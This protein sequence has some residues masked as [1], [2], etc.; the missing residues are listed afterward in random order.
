MRSVTSRA[1]PAGIAAASTPTPRVPALVLAEAS[2]VDPDPGVRGHAVQALAELGEAAWPAVAYLAHALLPAAG[3][4]GRDEPAADAVPRAAT[5]APL[6]LA[7]SGANDPNSDMP[8]ATAGTSHAAES[9]G[10]DHV[11]HGR[12]H[13]PNAPAGA[14]LYAAGVVAHTLT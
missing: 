6:H 12:E 14:P 9:G 2:L 3:T 11:G 13:V 7:E 8:S 10:T 1:N 4:P 5:G